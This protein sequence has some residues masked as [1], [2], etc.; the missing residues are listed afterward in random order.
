[1]RIGIARDRA[2]GFYYA[3]DLDALEA[4]GATLVPFDTL[5][6]P[7]LPEV[8][9]LYIG[10]GFPEACA[11]ELEANTRAAQRDQAGDR[12]AECRSMPSAAA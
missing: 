6:D 8:D 5:N 11:I 4:A 1:M 2:F 9:A 12:Q 7:H 3:D 10:G